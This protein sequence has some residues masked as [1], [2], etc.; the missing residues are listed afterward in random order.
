L[1]SVVGGLIAFGVA[2]LLFRGV[3][4]RDQDA[5][6]GIELALTNQ[7]LNTH[8]ADMAEPIADLWNFAVARQQ[9]LAD[10]EHLQ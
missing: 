5:W 9:S 7:L 3:D 4:P 10:D 2:W 1:I 8:G 6:D